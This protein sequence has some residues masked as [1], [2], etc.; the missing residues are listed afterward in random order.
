MKLRRSVSLA[1]FLAVLTAT[2]EVPIRAARGFQ[3]RA[4]QDVISFGD[5][6]LPLGMTQ[7][8]VLSG[9]L[10][11]RFDLVSAGGIYN[12]FPKGQAQQADSVGAVYFMNRTLVRV[13]KEWPIGKNASFQTSRSLYFA[14][15]DIVGGTAC[16]GSVSVN[17]SEGPKGDSKSVFITCGRRSV[18]IQSDRTDSL[19]EHVFIQEVLE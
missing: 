13:T 14:V 12:I 16:Q 6:S 2:L 17:S 15:L 8:E 18:H 4:S 10:T 3:Q 1:L 19:G 5:V 11:S 7:D 9:S